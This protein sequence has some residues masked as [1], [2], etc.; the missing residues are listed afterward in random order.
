MLLCIQLSLSAG[1]L[2]T[3]LVVGLLHEITIGGHAGSIVF[4]INS[5]MSHLELSHRCLGLALIFM[6]CM[7]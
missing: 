4:L 3:F 7:V 5:H 6:D 2:L 1:K